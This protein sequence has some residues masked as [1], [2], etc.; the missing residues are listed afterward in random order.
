MSLPPASSASEAHRTRG[1]PKR[2]VAPARGLA[3]ALA[4]ALAL[5]APLLCS[6]GVAAADPADDNPAAAPDAVDAGPA[7]PAIAAQSRSPDHAAWS[8]ELEGGAEYDSNIHR[9]ELRE[10]D[11]ADAV[12]APLMRL[13][14]RH[15]LIWHR[16]AG[17][18]LDLET[19]GGLKL[20]GSDSGQSENAA[21]V[22]SRG[23]YQWRLPG[24]GAAVGV[25]GNYYDAIAYELY[26]PSGPVYDNR[27]FRTGA[28]ELSATL[29]GPATHRLTALVGYRLFHYKPDPVF[30]WQGEHYQLVYQTT[31]WR[32]DPDQDADAASIDL[33]AGYE[34]E[35]RNYDGSARTSS[36]ADPGAGDP[37][38][39]AGTTL[40]RADLNHTVGAE[41]V[42]TGRRIYSARYELTVNDSNSFG[43]SLVRQRLRLGIT[44]ELLHD[45]YLTA[46]G[47]VL[48]NAYLD[49]LLVAS[50]EQARTFVSIDEENRNS[51]A[52]HLSRPVGGGWSLEG[53]YA[54][55]SNELS[56]Q[57]LSF[58]RQTAYLGAVYHY[59]P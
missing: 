16:T 18:R 57:E 20:F 48:F 17:E 22:S 55:Y 3:L 49:P 47:T 12:G 32:G 40:P 1:E 42:Y 41:L 24:R 33:T 5:V 29:L 4:M 54:I 28:G 36:C 21:V 31:W 13:G 23:G 35:R 10:G 58:R 19:F 37:A 30:D 34:L 7:V 26:P 50:D 44:T 45:L 9:L 25:S 6:A 52:V 38:C 39:S 2:P 11:T 43:E 15:R 8:L 46:Q 56:N 51:L 59:R 27:N 14:A 53:R